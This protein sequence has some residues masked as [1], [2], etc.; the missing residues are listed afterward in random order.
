M[1]YLVLEIWK[2]ILCSV[3][4]PLKITMYSDSKKYLKKK[5]Q[6]NSNNKKTYIIQK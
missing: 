3:Y 6:N 2:E 4:Y 5:K 1:F